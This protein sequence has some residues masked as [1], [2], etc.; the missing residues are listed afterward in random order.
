MSADIA[1]LLEQL[2]VERKLREQ[3]E[4]RA[5]QAEGRAEQA[6]K[7]TKPTNLIEYLQACHDHLFQA[8]SVQQNKSL[9][10]KG[11]VT[12]P[13]GKLCPNS[14]RPWSDFTTKQ[15]ET[16]DQLPWTEQTSS[17]SPRA[18]ASLQHLEELGQ[19]HAQRK[20]ASE[21]DLESFERATLENPV[22]RILHFL[23]SQPET[24]DLF[25]LDNGVEFEN[26]PNTLSDRSEEVTQRLRENADPSTPARAQDPPS[27][28]RADQICVYTTRDGRRIPILIVEYKAPHKLTLPHLRLGLREMDVKNEVVDCHTLPDKEDA[29]A[30]FQYHSDRLSAAVVTQVYTYMI[31]NGLEYSYI[32]TGEAFVFLRVPLDEPKTVLYH[33][34]DPKAEA[35]EAVEQAENILS[36]TAVGQVLAFCLL[37]LQSEPRGQAWRRK[38]MANPRRW[39]VDDAAILHEIPETVRKQE[40]PAS[41]FIPRTYCRR[42]RSSIITRSK[43]QGLHGCHDDQIVARDLEDSSA[44]SDEGDIGSTPTRKRG[45]LRQLP[46][47][48]AARRNRGQS[49][50]SHGQTRSYCTQLCL[51][52]LRDGGLLHT[53]CPNV[54]LHRQNV[55]D[56]HHQLDQAGFCSHLREQ[57]EKDLDS[58][59]QALGIQGSRGA[60]FK[61]TLSPYGYTVA[62]KGTVGAFVRDLQHEAAIYQ[63]LRSLQGRAIPVCL[64]AIDLVHPH[65]YDIGVR[66]VHMMLL[67]WGGSCLEGKD[68]HQR[69][70]S[71]HI[72]HAVDAIHKAGVLHGDLR[73]A[74][75]LWNQESRRVMLIDFERA[76]ICYEPLSSGMPLCPVSPNKRK[77]TT[78]LQQS[79]MV[80]ASS[81]YSLA[82][83][84]LTMR[85]IDQEYKLPRTS[86]RKKPPPLTETR[87][88]Q[89]SLPIASASKRCRGS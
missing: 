74:N 82:R 44:D 51:R 5:E 86:A 78:D 17:S 66:I 10:T 42:A 31:E 2:Q 12:N 14:M 3:A 83:E 26:H 56:R 64:G 29:D 85:G 20:L 21:K 58:N 43:S 49:S 4:G 84:L 71:N 75:M 59:C 55:G 53:R 33:L 70:L 48:L 80:Y 63:H 88:V 41:A 67:A 52:G 36:R 19:E 15:Q 38:A 87:H 6:E 68:E 7:L 23:C 81:S 89:F 46:P 35:S 72:R 8:F 18:F 62:A 13:E 54:E 47:R 45:Q 77:T 65:Y 37:A 79:L 27:G 34:A 30:V 57:L 73:M 39:V 60:L 69:P 50:Q 16:F 22:A 32:T 9:T 11:T 40:P 76:K 61:V 25:N 28:L 24:R 1:Q